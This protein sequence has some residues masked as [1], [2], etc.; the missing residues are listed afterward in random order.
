MHRRLTGEGLTV[1]A[2]GAFAPNL[3]KTNPK[4]EQP[5]L[6]YTLLHWKM[7]SAFGVSF[8]KKPNS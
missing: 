4:T 2:L 7:P 5:I 3:V 1:I 8:K 6:F